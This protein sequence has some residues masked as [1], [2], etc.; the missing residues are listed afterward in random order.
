MKKILMGIGFVGLCLLI[1]WIARATKPSPEPIIVETEIPVLDSLLKDSLTDEIHNRA[2]RI[3]GLEQAYNT[4]FAKWKAIKPDTVFIA[5]EPQT[6]TLK[7]EWIVRIVRTV[8]ICSVYT[9]RIDSLVSKDS[10]P[11]LDSVVGTS[12]LYPFKF[13]ESEFIITTKHDGIFL[14]TKKEFPLSF[15]L[16][17]SV[18]YIMLNDTFGFSNFEN[19][20]RFEVGVAV[21]L[22]YR[23]KLRLR[24]EIYNGDGAWKADLFLPVIK[25]GKIRG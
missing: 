20:N 6:F 9:F 16:G 5:S 15:M 22:W 18:R 14:K 12:K 24:T 7:H 17:P 25:L 8:D 21:E 13:K 3:L 4:L 2:L 23:D 11:V 10:I 1:F 19:M